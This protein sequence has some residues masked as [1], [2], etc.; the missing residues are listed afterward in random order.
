MLLPL[1][2]RMAPRRLLGSALIA[3]VLVP[4]L[5]AG[6]DAWWVRPIADATDYDAMALAAFSR[7]TFAQFLIA[8]WRYDWYLTLEVS[9]IGYQVAVFGRLLLGLYVARTLDLGSL[10]A[11]RDL[12]RRVLIAGGVAGLIGNTVFAGR[13]LS[14]AA[15]D[16]WLAMGRRLLVEGGKLGLTLAYASALVLVYLTARGRAVVRVLAPIGQMALTWYLLQTAFGIWMFYGFAHGPALMGKLGPASLAGLALAGY[17]VQVVLARG[18]MTRFRFGP[19]EWCWR[20]LT[21]WRIQPL[22]LRH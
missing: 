19:A 11:H 18:W 9:Q 13:L 5:V 7:G 14:G 21:Y 4:A 10:G 1:F 2:A 20:S 12:L 3:G 6:A 17:A 8:N 22:V 16:A 15:D